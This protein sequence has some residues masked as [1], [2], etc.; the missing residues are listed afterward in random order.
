MPRDTSATTSG[1][2]P[3]RAQVREPCTARSCA[4]SPAVASAF[5][6]FLRPRGIEIGP[7]RSIINFA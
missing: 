4:F 6:S 5:L 1:L 7:R 2:V 3:R